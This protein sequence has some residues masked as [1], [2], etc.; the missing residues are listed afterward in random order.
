MHTP[1]IDGA[2][3]D[4]F[5]VQDRIADALAQQLVAHAEA[6]VVIPTQDRQT[7][8]S[9]GRPAEKPLGPDGVTGALTINL[10]ESVEASSGAAATGAGFMRPAL[11]GRPRTVAV[12]TSRPPVIDGRLDDPVWSDATHITEFVQ[13]TPLEGAPGTEETEVWTAYDRDNLYFALYA[14][15]SDPGIIRAN[16]SE[17]DETPGDDTISVMFDPF[18]DQQRAYQFSVNG[19]GIR[20][21]AIV[22]AGQ[23]GG[24][25]RAGRGSPRPGGQ[26]GGASASGSGGSRRSSSS[27][28]GIRGD[29]SWDTLFDTRGQPVD[30]GWTA[31]MAIPF[32]N[33]RYPSRPSGQPH[34]WGFQIVRT[35]RGKSESVVWSP[36]SRSI[37]GQMTQ[38]GVLEGLTDLSTSRNLE[39]LPTLTAVQA[40]SLDT[41][42]GSFDEG[43]PDGEAGFGLKYGVTPDLTADFT[44]NPTSLRL[45]PIGLRSRPI[46]GLRCSFPSSARSS[47]KGRRSSVR[48]HRST[49]FT[50]GRS[51]THDLVAS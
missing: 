51:S 4:L 33:L 45:R 28:S 44:Y 22:S 11:A 29:R 35:I 13:M 3:H 17:R 24:S 49:W 6:E 2:M 25:S 34:R 18:M 27:T 48:R 8:P 30:D 43:N 42:T 39:F 19:Y 21:D 32:K 16:R 46:S 14:H 23:T 10:S 12:Q 7:M 1:K 38:M 41:Q 15:Y 26:S 47:S 20:S 37:A 40:G 31:E 36:V 5:V 50:H 9:V